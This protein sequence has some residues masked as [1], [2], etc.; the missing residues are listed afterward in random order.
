MNMMI[1][2]RP[3]RRSF[4]RLGDVM[5]EALEDARLAA[6]GKGLAFRTSYNPELYVHVDHDRTRT[7]VQEAVDRV[8]RQTSVGRVDVQVDDHRD[9]LV[10]HVRESSGRHFLIHLPKQETVP[11]LD[12][13]VEGALRG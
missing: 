13:R 4:V 1:Q 9:E 10:I 12:S 11:R 5:D 8:V 2:A 3:H 6:T 7:T